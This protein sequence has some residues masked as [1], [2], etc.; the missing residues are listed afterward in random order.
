MMSLESSAAKGPASPPLDGNS[1]G[2]QRKPPMMS[3]AE[4]VGAAVGEGD[5]S[6]VGVGCAFGLCVAGLAGGLDAGLK[7]GEAQAHATSSTP[8]AILTLRGRHP[9]ISRPSPGVHG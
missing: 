9:H 1:M 7:L 6:N 3:P 2:S 8:A 4:E 5:V